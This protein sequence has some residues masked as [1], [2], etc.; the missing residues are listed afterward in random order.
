MTGAIQS[1]GGKVQMALT[2]ML[3]IGLFP[4]IACSSWWIMWQACRRPSSGIVALHES[5]L[6]PTPLTLLQCPKPAHL[7]HTGRDS[8][9]PHTCQCSLDATIGSTSGGV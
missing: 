2:E 5:V 3:F 8:D 7:R 4:K 9:I 6:G 1:S